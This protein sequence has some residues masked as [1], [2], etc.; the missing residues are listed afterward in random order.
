M[1]DILKLQLIIFVFSCLWGAGLGFLYDCFRI[2]RIM[3]NPRNIFIFFQDVIYFIISGLITFLF[4]LKFNHGEVRFYILAGEGIGWIIYH[5]T[6]G[7]W[8]YKFS[9]KIV[10]KLNFKIL[11]FTNKIKLFSARFTKR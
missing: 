5:T 8:I 7:E 4:V 11:Q 9:S 3:I 6:L 10:K 1:S 2:I